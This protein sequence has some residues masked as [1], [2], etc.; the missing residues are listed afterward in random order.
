MTEHTKKRTDQTKL[1]CRWVDEEGFS[2]TPV[3]GP[4]LDPKGM[5]DTAFLLK[6]QLP[7]R[8]NRFPTP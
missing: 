5:S 3:A 2:V 8:P 1:P 6:S 7:P 4:A